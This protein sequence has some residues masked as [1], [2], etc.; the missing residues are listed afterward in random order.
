MG[1]KYDW[2]KG[3]DNF[4][5]KSWR[6]FCRLRRGNLKTSRAWAM[7]ERAMKLWDYSYRGAAE[8]HFRWW[9]RWATHSRLKPM[10]EKAK[11]LKNSDCKPVVRKWG[12]AP[13]RSGFFRCFGFADGA[14]PLFRTVNSAPPWKKGTGT[15]RPRFSRNSGRYLL[16]ASPHFP[17]PAYSLSQE[18]RDEASFIPR[19]GSRQARQ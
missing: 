11:M 9:Y 8:D 18:P 2:L 13:S 6:A 4:D 3:R 15:E 5:E 10:I 17:L 1:T 16:G 7:R 14:C 19:H 12:R